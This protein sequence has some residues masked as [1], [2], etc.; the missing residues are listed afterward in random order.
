M[1]GW[2]QDAGAMQG[3]GPESKT[4]ADSWSWESKEM[5]PPGEYSPADSLHLDT[6]PPEL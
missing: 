3:R 2:K 4:Q 6:Q 5:E 1:G